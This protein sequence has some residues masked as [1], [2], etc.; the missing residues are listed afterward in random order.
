L[1]RAH[2]QPPAYH[3]GGR[4]GYMQHAGTANLKDDSLLPDGWGLVHLQWLPLTSKCIVIGAKRMQAGKWYASWG[5]AIKNASVMLGP[6]DHRKLITS[7]QTYTTVVERG[8]CVSSRVYQIDL[9]TE[10]FLS[11]AREQTLGNS[12][13]EPAG[14]NSIISILQLLAYSNYW[15]VV[16]NS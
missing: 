11:T 8:A 1:S 7:H 10:S 14:S 16:V 15:L 6:K 5:A 2:P 9:L 4:Y 12:D 3:N 13:L